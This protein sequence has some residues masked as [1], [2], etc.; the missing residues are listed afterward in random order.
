MEGLN[1][2]NDLT[3]LKVGRPYVINPTSQTS[4]IIIATTTPYLKSHHR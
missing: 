1:H 2:L 3:D 4:T